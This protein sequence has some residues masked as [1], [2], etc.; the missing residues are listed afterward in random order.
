MNEEKRE[1]LEKMA[2]FLA[3]NGLWRNFC[4]EWD[5]EISKEM[6]DY[7]FPFGIPEDNE[8]ED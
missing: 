7:L 1:L 8:E 2:C 6:E 5:I 3:D 4:E